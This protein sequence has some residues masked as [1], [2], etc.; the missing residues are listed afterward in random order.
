MKNLSL[1]ITLL[2]LTCVFASSF[3]LGEEVIE[4]SQL[5]SIESPV[6]EVQE[7]TS[8][9]ATQTKNFNRVGFTDI[10]RGNGWATSE[11]KGSLIYGFWAHQAYSINGET[12][13]KHLTFGK[14]NFVK[15]GSYRIVK[16]SQTDVSDYL[17]FYV[18][19]LGAKEKITNP[20][21]NSLG[22]L[23][24]YKE[25]E[26]SNL[27]MWNGTLVVNSGERQ[28][29]YQVELGT[30]K[31]VVRPEVARAAAGAVKD[32]KRTAKVSFWKRMQLRREANLQ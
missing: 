24:L 13:T 32:A 4:V 31:D 3:V 8:E 27:I 29:T 22:T 16:K 25:K 23:S 1:V 17:E 19:P 11:E 14:I 21:A 7:V 10:W 9:V 15:G 6:S 30:V 20:E 12:D 5:E 28:G 26:Y 18:L 2:L